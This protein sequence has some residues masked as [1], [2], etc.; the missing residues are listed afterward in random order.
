MVDAVHNALSGLMA[1]AK[2]AGVAANNIANTQ[3]TGPVQPA[4][5]EPG[6]YVPQDVVSVSDPHG[7]VR[8]DV[9]NRDPGTE[10][11]YNPNDPHAD[12]NGQVAAPNV[13]LTEEIVQFKMAEMAYKASAKILKAAS[14]MQDEAI[15]IL[16][17]RV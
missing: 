1:S 2:R 13:D 8:A 6:P 4:S 12:E 9:V 10:V 11:I 7:G 16:D 3:T 15:R 17:D 14:D 5:G